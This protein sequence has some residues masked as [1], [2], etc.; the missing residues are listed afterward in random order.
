MFVRRLKCLHVILKDGFLWCYVGYVYIVLFSW[1]YTKGNR[2]IT[3]NNE[4]G[5]YFECKE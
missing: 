1:F 5:V 2:F 4:I 3:L